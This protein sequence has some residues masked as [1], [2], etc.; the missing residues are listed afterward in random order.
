V[1]KLEESYGKLLFNQ[2]QW[3]AIAYAKDEPDLRK[4]LDNA[5][6]GSTKQA[7]HVAVRLEAR[8]AVESIASQVAD[9]L[10]AMR[11]D[12][13]DA[14]DLTALPRITPPGT[15]D[16]LAAIHRSTIT[17]LERHAE[18][19]VAERP[20]TPFNRCGY[21]LH[22]VLTA[23]RPSSAL[24]QGTTGQLAMVEIEP[25]AATPPE[26]SVHRPPR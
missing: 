4:A 13:G 3:D 8:A 11:L 6:L 20:R 26:V 9:L 18:A 23:D 7:F 24:S 2:E 14:V 17:L 15:S 25:Y 5:D 1:N 19:I 12:S 10:D 16:R 22:D 21:L